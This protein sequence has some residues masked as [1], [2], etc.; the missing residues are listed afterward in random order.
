MIF[1]LSKR[2]FPFFNTFFWG[3]LNDNMF[4]NALVIMITYQSGFSKGT[5]SALSYLAMAALM[6]PQFPFSATAGQVADKY[7]QHK[8][9]RWIKFAEIL[10]ML[11]TFAAFCFHTIPAVCIPVLL[12][13]LFFMGTQSAFYSPVK[14]AYIPR[15]MPEDL[16]RGN[17]CV[18]A[19][20]YLAILFGTILGNEVITLP[21]GAYVTGGLLVL[22]ALI[23]YGAARFIPEL[24]SPQ[25]DLRVDWNPVVSTKP[26]M[27][28]IFHDFVLRHCVIGLSIFWM[29]GAL[30][31]SQLAGFCKEVIGA[32]ESLVM[33]FTL[34]FSVGVALG[35]CLCSLVRKRFNV[36]RL[37]PVTL[38]LMAL[39]TLDLFFASQTWSTPE[40]ALGV[41]DLA[42]IPRFYRFVADLILLAMC[43]GFYSVPLIALL[44]KTAKK[45]E[46]ARVV[47]GNNIINAAMIGLGSI[48]SAVL[49]FTGMIQVEG[50][51]VIVACINFAA[52]IYLMRLK[53]CSV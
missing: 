21:Y 22:I 15:N 39:F 8:L 50:I 17:A 37:V 23:G 46:M 13:L 9:F 6:L 12:V 10:L 35:S 53:N 48:C 51:F 49:M 43:G 29:A 20:T 32:K 24:P 26:I 1:V 31:V 5:A 27:K 3:A 45:E 38:I 30:Y 16:V 2:F 42:A 25:P 41:C 36:V 11:L 19:G 18:S 34:L 40:C 7:P 47:A 52:A 14:Y 28:T 44:Q 33:I 4:R